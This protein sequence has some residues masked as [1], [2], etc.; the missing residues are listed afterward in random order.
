MTDL[1]TRAIEVPAGRHRV[2]M[3]VAPRSLTAGLVLSSIGIIVG[4]IYA[5]RRKKPTGASPARQ[6]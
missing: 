4:V 1:G 6:D 5:T 2:A 3:T